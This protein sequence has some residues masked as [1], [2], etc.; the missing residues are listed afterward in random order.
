MYTLC[1]RN[2]LLIIDVIFCF[3]GFIYFLISCIMIMN[4][5]L[6]Y[7]S[8]ILIGLLSGGATIQN[9]FIA[10]YQNIESQKSQ[11]KNTESLNHEN[12]SRVSMNILYIYLYIWFIKYFIKLLNSHDLYFTYFVIY[13]M[14]FVMS[15]VYYGIAVVKA[16]IYDI[17][18]TPRHGDNT[19]KTVLS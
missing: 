3:H 16:N 8:L 11:N 14:S 18:A 2:S 15:Y 19:C 4:I 17:Q 9:I 6:R 1:F 7:W 5:S 13:Y 10:S 12:K